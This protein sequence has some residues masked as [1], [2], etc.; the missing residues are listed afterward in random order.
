MLAQSLHFREHFQVSK[1]GL[2]AV[3]AYLVEGRVRQL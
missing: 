2:I 3:N 1:S